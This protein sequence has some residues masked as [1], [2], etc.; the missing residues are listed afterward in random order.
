MKS[1]RQPGL[2]GKPKNGAMHEL[3]ICL[4]RRWAESDPRGA[5]V[6]SLDLGAATKLDAIAMGAKRLS[7]NRGVAPYASAG[8]L[9]GRS[10]GRLCFGVEE[11]S[12]ERQN[13]WNGTG[14]SDSW[15]Q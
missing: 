14:D 5:A 3:L 10:S 8:C 9:V 13:T 6:A 11:W 12:A 4:L 15:S 1:C 7:Q 2:D